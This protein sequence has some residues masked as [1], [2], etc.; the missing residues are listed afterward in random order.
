ME[1]SIFSSK[2]LSSDQII[3][4]EVVRL[5]YKELRK[6]LF[7]NE[8]ERLDHQFDM[9]Y[10]HSTTATEGNTCTLAEVTRILENGISPKGRSLREVYEIRNFQDVLQYRNKYRGKMSIRLMQKLHE[11]IMRDIDRFTLGSF[12]RIELA[13]LGSNTRPVPAI[14]SMRFTSAPSS[15]SR[16]AQ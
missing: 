6:E 4:V 11:L 10:I 8:R 15:A 2:V 7:P 14:F 13:I 16:V 12:R 9:N 5:A 3:L 1:S